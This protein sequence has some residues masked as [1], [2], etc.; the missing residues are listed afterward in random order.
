[1]IVHIFLLIGGALFGF[2]TFSWSSLVISDNAWTV[3]NCKQDAVEFG[4]IFK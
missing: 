3:R 4:G 1:M 2:F